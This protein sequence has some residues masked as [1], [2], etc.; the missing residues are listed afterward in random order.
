MTRRAK[1]AGFG[2]FLAGIA[3]W[4]VPGYTAEVTSGR[5][6]VVSGEDLP[7]QLAQPVAEM[8]RQL[9]ELGCSRFS[10]AYWSGDTPARL[11]IEVRCVGWTRDLLP[12]GRALPSQAAEQASR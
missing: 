3:L 6:V 10:R 9:S 2:V 4:A 1:T 5:D 12:G 7:G 11:R 8:E